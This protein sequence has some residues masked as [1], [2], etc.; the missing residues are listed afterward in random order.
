M[1]LSGLT[2]TETDRVAL[3][4]ALAKCMAD[5]D[6]AE[7]VKTTLDEDGWRE[8]AEDSAYHC[9]RVASISSRGKSRRVLPTS[10]IFD[11]R[12]AF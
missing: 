3:E 10:T 12:R 7:H 2:M 8:A 1:M 6:R 11:P 4:V 5:P 9:Q